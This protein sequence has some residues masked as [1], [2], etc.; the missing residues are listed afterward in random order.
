MF[1]TVI[2][3]FLCQFSNLN[4]DEHSCVHLVVLFVVA[5]AS[6]GRLT[7]QF[8]NGGE[9]M[10]VP[11]NYSYPAPS[12][13]PNYPYYYQPNSPQAP[14]QQQQFW[15]H[16][17]A[18]CSYVAEVNQAYGYPPYGY[19]PPLYTPPPV[20]HYA[21]DSDECGYSST[22]EM[23]YYAAFFKKY[24]PPI[25]PYRNYYPDNRAQTPQIIITPSH[26]TESNDCVNGDFNSIS[27]NGV[28]KKDNYVEVSPSATEDSEEIT[29]EGSDTEVEDE[30]KQRPSGLQTIKSVPDISIYKNS[31]SSDIQS[32]NSETDEIEDEDANEEDE[33][34]DE[35]EEEEQQELPHQLSVIFEESEHSEC[36]SLNKSKHKQIDDVETTSENESSTATL[37]NG[38]DTDDDLVDAES[39]MVLVRLPLKLQFSKTENDEEVT[40]VTVGDSEIRSSPETEVL[41][42][43]LIIQDL[44]KVEEEPEV[45]VTF[46]IPKKRGIPPKEAISGGISELKSDKILLE[47]NKDTNDTSLAIAKIK[48]TDDD[49]CDKEISFKTCGDKNMVKESIESVRRTSESP[50]DFWKE[51][52]CDNIPLKAQVA[53]DVSVSITL[54]PESLMK[55]GSRSP[56][57]NLTSESE[58]SRPEESD[59]HW[60]DDSSSTSVQTV[61]IGKH[62]GSDNFSGSEYETTGTAEEIEEV[63]QKDLYRNSCDAEKIENL[64]EYESVSTTIKDTVVE[65][66]SERI[67]IEDLLYDDSSSSDDDESSSSISSS[68]SS[69]EMSEQSKE[70]EETATT[71]TSSSKAEEKVDDD[72]FTSES[73]KSEASNHLSVEQKPRK[74]CESSCKSQEDSEEDDSGV[75]SDMSRHISETDTDPECGTELRKL[76]PYQRASTHSRLFKLLQD[77]CGSEDEEGLEEEKICVEKDS[78]SSRKERL[79]LPLQTSISDPDSMSSSSGINSPASPTVSDKLVKELVQSLLHKRKGRHFRK[80]PMDKL[81][82]AAMRILQE[83]MDPYDTVSSTSDESFRHSPI[84]DT[85]A[86]QANNNTAINNSLQ[87]HESYGENYYDYCDYYNTWGNPNYYSNVEDSLGYDILPSRAFR[88]LQERS[89]TPHGFSSGVIDGL[90]AKC[91]RVLSLQDDSKDCTVVLPSD[92]DPQVSSSSK[93]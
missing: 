69:D 32:L 47:V 45:S 22:D 86:N 9:A 4:F 56:Y 13:D 41:E 49:I 18:M 7:P 50:V 60:E 19:P 27:E 11:P 8:S 75:T 42:G 12:P 25:Q 35:E 65:N 31:S 48:L 83:D 51:L 79:S 15:D 82:A 72:V 10:W 43:D 64:K 29:D 67:P 91:P 46:T 89:Q 16:Y 59:G 33:E 24:P 84:C 2:I 28:Y 61:R 58:E 77:E 36:E 62:S 68:E 3:K 92:P 81:Y 90:S 37:D 52:S 87:N 55:S 40:T 73:S 63:V 1:I 30:E 6:D 21:S 53:A 57:D 66:D 34:E 17:N 26:K 23:N 14:E 80:L 44:K 70:V 5:V 74:V 85:T 20:T 38:E 76:T 78:L 93:T 88:L 71:S 39:S 54:S